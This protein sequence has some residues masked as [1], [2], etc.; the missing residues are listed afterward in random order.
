MKKI[1]SFLLSLLPF[2]IIGFGIGLLA[3]IYLN[4]ETLNAVIERFPFLSEF[5]LIYFL[6]LSPL[7]W[8]TM[9]LLHELGHF[10]AGTFCRFKF[11]FLSVGPLKFE[12]NLVG[13][14]LTSNRHMNV[15][16]GLTLMIPEEKHNSSIR[17]VI[18]VATGPLTSLAVGVLLFVF[19]M[20]LDSGQMS[21][22]LVN[23]LLGVSLSSLI[24]GFLL[25][26]IPMNVKELGGNDAQ[27]ILD[28]LT[29]GKT[30]KLKNVLFKLIN[31]SVEGTRPAFL[32]RSD[33]AKLIYY[34]RN[35]DVI[36]QVTGHAF[37][38]YHYLERKMLAKAMFHLD[39]QDKLTQ[40]EDGVLLRS[41]VL[42]EKAWLSILIYQNAEKAESFIS[43]AENG[44]YEASVMKRVK[45]GVALLKADIE[46]AQLE[47]EAG[48]L[49]ARKN[50]DKGGNLFEI[51]MLESLRNRV[52][53]K[54]N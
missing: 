42:L 33:I 12:K 11:Y 43:E 46:R 52:L 17:W 19:L 8:Y 2:L 28:T 24:M 3:G 34:S 49:E 10:V 1:F 29:G 51:E 27:M 4:P 16:G 6:L 13:F 32:N 48:I 38:Y 37:A 41:T 40:S 22:L 44:Y 53:P 31:A 25:S 39:W 7:W 20:S 35:V 50:K 47:A 26:A 54:I 5:S 30:L 23:F 36:S 18:F 15:T 21:S 9:I 14:R 45:A